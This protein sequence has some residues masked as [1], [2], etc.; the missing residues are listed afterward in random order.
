M[1][2]Q[3]IM[4]SLNADLQRRWNTW[5]ATPWW[6]AALLILVQMTGGMRDMPTFAFFLIYLQE[7]IG[8]TPSAISGVV[9]GGQFASMLAALLGG[10]ITAHLGSKWVL[11]GGLIL[12]GLS[13]LVFQIHWLWLVVLLWLIGGAGSA[14]LT[15]GGASY[16]TRLTDRGALG[17]LSALYVLSITIGGAV[18]N[19]IAGVLIEQRGF[20]AFGW[21]ATGLA[22]ISVLIVTVLLPHQHDQSTEPA[23][24]RTFLSTSLSAA[25]NKKAQLLIG[26]RCLPTIFYGMSLVLI[27]LLLNTLSGSKVMVAAYGTTALIVASCAQLLAGRAADRWGARLP[28][29]VGYSALIIAGIGLALTAG[30]VWGLFIFGVIGVAAAW[31]LSAMMYVWVTDGISKAEHPSTFG[32]LHAVWSFSMISGSVLGGWFVLTTPGLPFLL[33]G[34]LNGGSLLLTVAYYR[35]TE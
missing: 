24:A 25:H 10:A 32:M 23:S 28:T 35:S 14:I 31:S 15:V 11:A 19:P 16:L 18:G 12:A 13:S 4:S 21:A 30:T 26:M 1:R 33:A 6:P 5:R 29:L 9:A 2:E 27:P 3:A 7:Q 34:L 17:I 22:I 8:L 20:G